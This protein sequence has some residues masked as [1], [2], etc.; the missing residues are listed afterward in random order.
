MKLDT[1]PRI[2]AGPNFMFSLK[3]ILR[4]IAQVVNLLVDGVAQLKTTKANIDSP[5][6]TGAPM[7][8]TPASSDDST[9]I[10]TTAWARAG[11]AVSLGNTGYI[12]LPT[13]LGGLILQW[14]TAVVTLSGGITPA[15]VYPIVFPA[16]AWMVLVGNGD[17][18]ATSIMP[19][20]NIW[21][22]TGFFAE[23]PAGGSSLVRL[24]WIAL[25]N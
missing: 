18:G 12:K 19:G 1:D 23:F 16:A 11:F 7:A 10:A 17:T 6:F 24:N 25:G 22:T 9:R 20:V 4:K 3:E 14:G 21:N 13:W 2:E 8:P 5:N 15:V